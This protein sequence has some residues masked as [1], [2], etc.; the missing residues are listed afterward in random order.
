[1][2]NSSKNLQIIDHQDSYYYQQKRKKTRLRRLKATFLVLLLLIL[3][4]VFMPL[5]HSQYINHLLDAEPLNPVE[6]NLINSPQLIFNHP[7]K[8]N[9][10]AFPIDIKVDIEINGLV[11]YAKINQVFINPYDLALEG[12]YQFPLPRKRCH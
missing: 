3:L 10:I 5:A 11:A 6:N 2:F 12:K 1:M 7:D 4:V 9:E 8:Q